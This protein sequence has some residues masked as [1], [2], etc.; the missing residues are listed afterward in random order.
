M[1]ASAELQ[2][3]S[4]WLRSFRARLMRWFHGSARELPWREN[5]DP[6]RVWLSEIM[7]QQTQV[8]TVKGYF[9]RFTGELPTIAALAA[10]E[11]ATVL[12]LWEGL[13]YYRR[14]RQLHAAARKIVAEHGGEFPRSAEEVRRLP[15]IGR[16]TAG[17]IL[18]IAF[19]QRQP[20]VEAN[21]IRLYSR[22][23]GYRGDPRDS[24]GQRRL[25]EF[26]EQVLPRQ[27]SGAMNQALMELGALV[28][29]PRNPLCDSCPVNSLCAARRLGLQAEI[30]PPARKPNFEQ[31][32][33]AAVLL[34]R[35]GRLLVRRCEPGERWAGLWDFPRCDATD[36]AAAAT[37]KMDPV[38]G[39]LADSLQERYGLTVDVGPRLGTLK[40]GVTRYRITLH[41]YEGRLV[42]TRFKEKDGIRWVT[43][44]ELAELPLSSTGR[45]LA[46]F[47][48]A[49]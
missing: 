10:A 27:G 18:S 36:A 12:R 46:Q 21:T 45:K 3:D 35:R 38:A 43:P 20:I 4:A 23:L 40:H 1:D 14:A 32:V 29:T 11:E 13:G 30:P 25:W 41:Y 24:A 47:A 7:L 28:C 2:P 9:E 6:Y 16:Y 8:A 5:C 26:A 17:A 22:L 39:R 15:G 48:G 44:A 31:L 42:N 19:D 49:M 33:E 37:H 34:R